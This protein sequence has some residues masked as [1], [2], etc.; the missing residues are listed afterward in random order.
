MKTY[1]YG[2]GGH[3]TKGNSVCQMNPIPQKVVEKTV[4]DAVLDFYQQYL[5]PGGKRRLAEAVRDQLGTQADGLATARKRIQEGQDE[6][7]SIINNLLDNLT[8]ENR[9]FVNKRLAELRTRQE[10]LKMRDEELEC[11]E[12]AQASIDANVDEA[13][14]FLKNLEFTLREGLP[15]EQLVAIRQCV[16][17]VQVNFTK[18][19]CRIRLRVVPA[20]QLPAIVDRDIAIANSHG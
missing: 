8:T 6:L 12:L 3:I 15:Q 14:V 13:I 17:R 16:E 2:C 7:D 1:A 11:L 4:I 18:F 20:G 5:A 19:R 10:K 9:G